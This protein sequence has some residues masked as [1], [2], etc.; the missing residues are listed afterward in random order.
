MVDYSKIGEYLTTMAVNAKEAVVT[1][2]FAIHQLFGF[3]GCISDETLHKGFEYSIAK[4][5][6]EIEENPYLS[7]D[8][9]EEEK[10]RAEAFLKTCEEYLKGQL[11]NQGR[12]L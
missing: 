10:N 5:K 12:L 8:Q 11:K 3:Y 7:Y 4:R 9:K 1:T 2:D 6:K